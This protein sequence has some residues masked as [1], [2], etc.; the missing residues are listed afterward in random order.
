M[1][2]ADDD[3]TVARM[4]ACSGSRSEASICEAEMS[5]ESSEKSGG[6]EGFGFARVFHWSRSSCNLV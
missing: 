1:S 3:A 4:A 6:R 5:R 2:S